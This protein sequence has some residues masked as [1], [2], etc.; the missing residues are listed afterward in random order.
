MNIL[1]GQ[2]ARAR[3]LSLLREGLLTGVY[4]RYDRVARASSLR[5]S[6]ERKLE[7]CATL[8]LLL[9]WAC[10]SFCTLAR[11]S[12]ISRP[13]FGASDARRANAF[14]GSRSANRSTSRRVRSRD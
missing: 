8:A 2:Q 12:G 13:S 10:G 14:E 4:G 6:F 3:Q 7:A 5:F 9:F 11:A 1:S